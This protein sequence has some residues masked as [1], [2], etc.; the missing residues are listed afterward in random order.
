VVPEISRVRHISKSGSTVL[1]PSPYGRLAFQGDRLRQGPFVLAGDEAGLD[2]HV[3]A[4]ALALQVLRATGVT[5]VKFSPA[6]PRLAQ[7][8]VDHA[9][10]PLVITYARADL[11]ALYAALRVS[12]PMD[13]EPRSAFRGVI[14]LRH[15]VTHE[16]MFLCD[17]FLAQALP[18]YV[19]PDRHAR[20]VA[21]ER[22]Q[23]CDVVCAAW[24]LKCLP[25]ELLKFASPP[26]LACAQMKQ[27]FP[28]EQGCGHQ[29]GTELPAYSHAADTFHQ[30]LV[31]D[32]VAPSCE[33]SHP[34][35]A[36]A[37]T[38]SLGNF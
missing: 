23:S 26:G 29:V 3:Y 30:C 33:A 16:F 12:P 22:G 5:V 9:L 25:M 36:R 11:K 35:T 6:Q 31:G 24:S 27:L 20:L 32:S 37:C 7:V 21:G 19:P 13:S 8:E 2:E 34:D 15:P 10:G 14:T 18:S 28:C 1:D 38:C 17:T 4:R